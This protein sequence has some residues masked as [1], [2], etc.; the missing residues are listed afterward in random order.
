M[1]GGSKGLFD[2]EKLA[3]KTRSQTFVAAMNTELRED[4]TRERFTTMKE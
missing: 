3:Q 2:K 1:S 4:M